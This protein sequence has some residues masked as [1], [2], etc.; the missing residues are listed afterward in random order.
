[1]PADVRSVQVTG[2]SGSQRLTGGVYARQEEEGKGAEVAP[3]LSGPVARSVSDLATVVASAQAGGDGMAKV[4]EMIEKLKAKNL[5]LQGQ[6][7]AEKLAL[8]RALL[9]NVR[10]QRDMKKVMKERGE[11]ARLLTA[12]QA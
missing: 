3:G 1:M 10:Q 5:S 8:A 7:D 4:V 9:H 6:L 11:A 2:D 12:K